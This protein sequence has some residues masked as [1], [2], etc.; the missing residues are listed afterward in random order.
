[1]NQLCYCNS[2]KV[3]ENCCQP[4]ILGLKN[5][6]SAVECM[7][8][9][10]SA[11]VL[12]EVDYLLNS[13]FPSQRKYYS[14]SEIKAWSQ[15]NTWLKLEIIVSSLDVVEFKAYYLDAAN[16]QI[17]HH[18]KSKFKKENEFWYFYSGEVF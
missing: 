14:K 15:E 11:Y 9:R 5:A 6:T 10:Y 4:I 13:T 12:G 16:K 17:I 3:F 8:S 1:M 2:E 7:R 18:E